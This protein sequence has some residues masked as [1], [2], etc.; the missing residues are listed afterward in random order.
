MTNRRSAGDW[1]ERLDRIVRGLTVPSLLAR[2]TPRIAT[3]TE[4]ME[5]Y[6][7]PGISFAVLDD[8][9][10][11]SAYAAGVIEVGGTDAVTTRTLFQVGSLGKPVVAL[12]A[13]RLVEAGAIDIDADVNTMLT[14]WKIPRN[15][16]WQPRVTLRHVLTHTSGLTVPLYP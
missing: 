10:L 2:D 1:S 16:A 11:E 5:F 3:L 9:R 7:V 15:G 12:A 8:Y 4:R 14:S 13:L 6:K